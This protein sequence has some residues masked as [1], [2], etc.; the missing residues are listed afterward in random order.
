MALPARLR[1]DDIVRD[2]RGPVACVRHSSFQTTG[3]PVRRPPR[4]DTNSRR[5]VRYGQSVQTRRFATKRTVRI[6]AITRAHGFIVETKRRFFGR[7]RNRL[8]FREGI[9]SE[10]RRNGVISGSST[11]GTR[12]C[13]VRHRLRCC[14][15]PT[16]RMARNVRDIW[17]SNRHL[18][19]EYYRNIFGTY[20]LLGDDLNAFDTAPASGIVVEAWFWWKRAQC[21]CVKI[22][23]YDDLHTKDAG[24]SIP[25]G[26]KWRL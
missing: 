24:W 1:A 19:T 4:N 5:L 25:A 17:N 9:W 10:S 18:I 23:Y 20:C 3:N 11:C 12:S 6:A 2:F 7:R 13:T 22:M 14:Y 15:E 26:R 16:A 8:V 21:V